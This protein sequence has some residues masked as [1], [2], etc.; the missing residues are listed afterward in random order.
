MISQSD[1]FVFLVLAIAAAV[2]VAAAVVGVV[3]PWEKCWAIATR[4]KDVECI[5]TVKIIFIGETSSS[6]IFQKK[7]FFQCSFTSIIYVT[8]NAQS[9]VKYMNFKW[10]AFAV[11]V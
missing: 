10:F 6:Q 11:N 9:L 3:F 8:N 4:V 1:L 2:A 7:N 5:G